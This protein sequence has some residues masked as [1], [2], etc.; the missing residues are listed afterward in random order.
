MTILSKFA[1]VLGFGSIVFT[2]FIVFNTPRAVEQ[3]A[4]LDFPLTDSLNDA[5]RITMMLPTFLAIAA[6][7]VALTQLKQD[8]GGTVFVLVALSWLVLIGV[9]GIHGFGTLGTR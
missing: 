8:Y 4:R 7:V 5:A 6:T 9:L 1:L 3:A 2:L